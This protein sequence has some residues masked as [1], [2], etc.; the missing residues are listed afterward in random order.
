VQ[1]VTDLPAVRLEPSEELEVSPP[2]ERDR[3]TTRPDGTP[4][5]VGILGVVVERLQRHVDHRGSLIELINFDHSFWHEPIVHCECV[6]TRAGAIKGWGMHKLGHDRYFVGSGRMRV[7]LFD[8]RV[9]SPTFERFAQFHFTEQSPGLLRIPAGVWHANQNWGD[10]DAQFL[11]FPTRGYDH[12]HPDKYRLD[13]VDGP[14]EFDWTL[15]AG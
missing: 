12:A 2:A 1:G 11:N 14:I 5:D 6:T 3:P 8:G 10:E 9:Q 13:P 15:P 4:T 7:V